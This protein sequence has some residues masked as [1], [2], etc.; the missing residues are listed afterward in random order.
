MKFLCR[1]SVPRQK[2]ENAKDSHVGTGQ[3]VCP[4]RFPSAFVCVVGQ[5]VVGVRPSSFPKHRHGLLFRSAAPL[6]SRKSLAGGRDQVIAGGCCDNVKPR[7]NVK[8]TPNLVKTKT[9]TTKLNHFVTY[10]KNI[11]TLTASCTGV[12]IRRL[13]KKIAVKL[14]SLVPKPVTCTGTVGRKK[15]T[16]SAFLLCRSLGTLICYVA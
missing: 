10:H 14:R 8:P 11:P 6:S 4:S 7:I 5:K 2:S 1:T 12:L 9:H 3:A 15:E 13:A 16:S